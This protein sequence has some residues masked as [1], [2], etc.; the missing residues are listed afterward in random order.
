MA[1]A[2][3]QASEAALQLAQDRMQRAEILHAK[4][5]TPEAELHAA[6]QQVAIAHAQLA[7]ASAQQRLTSTSESE[8][9]LRAPFAGTVTR[10]PSGIGEVVTPGRALFH[11]EDLSSLVLRGGI[12]EKAVP[13]LRIGDK[14]ELETVPA[15]GRIQAL[16]PS[17]DSITRRAPL[18]IAVPNPDGALV[19]H[20]LVKGTIRTRRTLPALLVPPTAMRG[21]DTLFVVEPDDTIRVRQVQ[22]QIAPDGGGVVLAGLRPEDRVVV[23]PTPDLTEGLRVKPVTAAPAEPHKP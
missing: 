17:L 2:S 11:V 10:V 13:L 15:E 4:G 14:V 16:A 5:A 12:T 3:A 19:G 21:D 8:H 23:R 6:R 9:V 1:A 20:T 7:Q 18:E 22:S